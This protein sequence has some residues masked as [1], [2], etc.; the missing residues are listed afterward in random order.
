MGLLQKAANRVKGCYT[1]AEWKKIHEKVETAM[2]DLGAE[3][4][5][6]QKREVDA[7]IKE[8]RVLIEKVNR[9]QVS[10]V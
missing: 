5:E 6:E 7:L 9:L 1:G 4:A 2:K 10:D 8:S 3:L